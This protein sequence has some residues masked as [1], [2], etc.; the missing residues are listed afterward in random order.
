[1]SDLLKA[2]L[3]KAKGVLASKWYV[4]NSA[5]SDGAGCNTKPYYFAVYLNGNFFYYESDYPFYIVDN[6][7]NYYIVYAYDHTTRASTIAPT[8]TNYT[9]GNN[10]C[11]KNGI[12]YY[13]ELYTRTSIIQSKQDLYIWR[14]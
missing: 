9:T 3:T 4:I 5:V 12:V 10:F 13:E 8:P 2:V 14:A 6:G 1:M 7:G 11:T